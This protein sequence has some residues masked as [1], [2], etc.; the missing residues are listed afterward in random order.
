MLVTTICPKC[1]GSGWIV[2]TDA[3]T[4]YEFGTL[5]ECKEIEK[6]QRILENS[7]ITTTDIDGKSF[8][9]FDTRKM[10]TLENAKKS[11]ISY[12]KCF[13]DEQKDKPS[14][15]ICGQVGSGKSHLTIAIAG[16]LMKHCKTSVLYLPYRE[17]IGTLKRLAMDDHQEYERRLQK[18]KS[19]PVLLIDD[20]LKGSVTDADI[21]LLFEIVN[22][23]YLQKLPMIISTEK[24]VGDL[25]KVDEAI[26]SRIIEMA[27]GHIVEIKGMQYN[28]RLK[29]IVKG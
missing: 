16:N 24:F 27:S 4:G 21:N 14:F 8:S 1:N 10:A 11:A 18:Y 2:R 17:V 20:F 19:Y 12:A 23:R 9:S 29:D 7:G 5:C 22:E 13:L 25:L 26:A 6:A 28:Y 15:L 3:E